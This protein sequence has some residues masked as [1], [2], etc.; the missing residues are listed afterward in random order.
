[1]CDCIVFA[2]VGEELIVCLVELKSKTVHLGEVQ[3]KLSNSLRFVRDLLAGLGLPGDAV[4]LELFVLAESWTPA[5]S[6]TLRE[7]HR[8]GHRAERHLILPARCGAEL[9]DIL[10]R[11]PGRGTQ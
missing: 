11:V 7:K 10:A 8:V 4:R 9:L 5:A 6:R 3:E 1:M 2:A